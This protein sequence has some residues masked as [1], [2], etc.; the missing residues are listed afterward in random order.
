MVG[1]EQQLNGGG[2]VLLNCH[3]L[4]LA[5]FT[6]VRCGGGR[7]LDRVEILKHD[8]RGVR[9]ECSPPPPRPKRTHRELAAQESRLVLDARSIME[10]RGGGGC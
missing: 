4:D 1:I 10:S 2:E 6:E 3:G 7:S 5:E 9:E 8:L